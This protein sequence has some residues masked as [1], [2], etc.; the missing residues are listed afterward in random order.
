MYLY[1]TPKYRN[2]GLLATKQPKE[3]KSLQWCK[4]N[5]KHGH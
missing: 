2:K 3:R 5:N 1:I 4:K